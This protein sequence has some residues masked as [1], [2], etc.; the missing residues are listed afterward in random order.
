MNPASTNPSVAFAGTLTRA[1]FG[2]VQSMLLPAWARWYVI[3]PIAAIGAFF[4]VESI[5]KPSGLGFHLLL[6]I[7][8]LIGIGW[9]MRD[10]RTRAWKQF[11]DVGGR[12]RGTVAADGIEWNT[13]M[14][15]TRCEWAKVTRV[16]R[17]DGLT[18]AFYTPRC[19]FYFPR[20]FFDSDQAWTAFS[21]E[22]DARTRR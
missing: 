12:V 6:T 10:V 20:S 16:A 4:S 19:A 1:E 5:V 14:S 22:I 11:V 9:T 2:R 15:T 3:S 18:L 13:S 7:L 21:A 17:A 8:A